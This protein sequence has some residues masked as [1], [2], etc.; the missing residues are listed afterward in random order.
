MSEYKNMSKAL[1]KATSF[2]IPIKIVIYLCCSFLAIL[3]IL[4]LLNMLAISL[5]SSL[6]AESGKVT[7]WPV[8][9]TLDS[10]V[11][12]MQNKLL[13]RSFNISVVRCISTVI[14]STT[15]TL[16]MAYPLSKSASIYPTRKL[17]A[18]LLIFCMLFHGGIVPTYIVVANWLHLKDNFWVLVLPQTVAV[19][20]VI[21]AMNFIRS[22]PTEIEESAIIDGSS[23][24]NTLFKIIIPLLKP[25]IA[26][27]VLYTFVGTWNEWF[28]A[29]IYFSDIKNYPIQTLLRTVLKADNVTSLLELGVDGNISN[30]SLKMAQ[31]FITM[32]PILIIYPYLQKYFTTGIV[33]GAVKS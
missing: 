14:I 19:F 24:L 28:V 27:I 3:C 11:I 29:L 20:N 25:V 21:L 23:Y 8:D 22:L 32:I 15:I 5:S 17:Y 7:F 33:L 10:Y 31:V 2:S 4:P 12:M 13:W 6:A 1:Y 16:F 18:G 30:K 26:V 9:F